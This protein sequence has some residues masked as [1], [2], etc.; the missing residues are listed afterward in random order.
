MLATMDR[1]E[2]RRLSGALGAEIL[3]IDLAARLDEAEVAALRAALLEH[4][5]IFF[6]DQRLSPHD[7]LALARRFG[8]V[9]E[10]PFVKACPNARWSCR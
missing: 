3:G 8:E 2:V 5:V 10:Y 7:L 1:V 4:I 9:V 6:R